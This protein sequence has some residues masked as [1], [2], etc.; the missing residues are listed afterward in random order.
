VAQPGNNS[1]GFELY[2]S[3]VYNRWAFNQYSA[4]TASA[5]PVRV[6]QASAGGVTAGQ[7]THLV[8]TYSST[9][10]DLALYVDGTL[11]G[12]VPYT[13]PWDA[14]RGLQI[15]ASSYDG[16][17][18]AFFPGTIDDVR[19]YDK[20]LSATE[21][22]NLHGQ[23]AIGSGRPA[24]AIF[25]LDEDPADADGNPTTTLTGHAEVNPLTLEGGASLGADG[26]QDGALSLDGTDDYATT[27]P[28]L[29]NQR[30]Y[31]ITAWAKLSGTTPP[32]HAAI[33]AGQEGQTKPGVELYYSS[34]YGWSFDNYT[35]DDANGT[36]VRSA[37]GDTSHVVPGEWTQLT[38]TYD[39]V[40]DQLQLYVNGAPVGA[41][42]SFSHPFY[43]GGPFQ[44]G[45]GFGSGVVKNFFGGEIDDVR[46][47]DRTLTAPEVAALYTV[48]AAV[49]GH[50]KLDTAGGSPVTSADEAGLHPLTLGSGASIDTS[51]NSS[52]VGP[53]GLL[54]DGTANGYAS[55]AQSPIN[56]GS[57]F[58][59]SAWVA[60]SAR[61]QKTVTVMSMAGSQNNGFSVRYVPDATDPAD[62]GSW[63]LV[64][65]GADS[66]S[67]T[68]ATADAFQYDD[69]GF[70]TSLV[71]VYDAFAGEMR[72]YVN[73]NLS[74]TLCADDD[75]DGV[76]NDPA[77]TEKVSWNDQVQPFEAKGGL[78]IGRERT[79]TGAWGDYMSGAVD[80]VWLLQGVA[81][82]EQ[83][84]Q[85][86]D[87]ADVTTSEGP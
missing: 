5:T 22:A 41:P 28:H 58:T 35:S 12:T 60:L 18:S 13:T 74:R 64:M 4:D 63:Q 82:D 25:P 1:P 67:A 34:T 11:A 27:S 42:T 53:G 26:V 76:P 45:A 52:E 49:A 7:W 72:L 16:A 32:D 8:G 15:G 62:L 6:M 78:Q 44:V 43:A 51:G 73:G 20:P 69:V 9:D 10:D 50:W 33:V 70:M 55:T 14:R 57:S 40:A 30:G 39:P 48:R 56:T 21:V 77:C 66:T 47:Y 84:A 83:V 2:Y 81:S 23:Q 86:A 31:T 54:L 79:A 87:G 85:L 3:Q 38:G 36:V 19:V 68:V 37:Q 24:R 80:D 65:A 61:P 17:P 59:A 75:D 29:N 46:L 71:V